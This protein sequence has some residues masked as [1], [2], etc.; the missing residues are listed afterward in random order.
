[1]KKLVLSLTLAASVFSLSAFADE[2][3]GFISDSMCAAKHVGATAKD[4]AC[5]KKCVTG[6]SDPVFLSDGK[7]IKIAADSIPQAKEHAGESVKIDG[8]LN[9]DTVTISSISAASK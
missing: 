2:M 7:V 5:A 1:M 4:S 9:G 6:G 3:T 8:T